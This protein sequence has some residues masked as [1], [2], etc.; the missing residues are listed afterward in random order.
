MVHFRKTYEKLGF[1]KRHEWLAKKKR[2]ISGI[3]GSGNQVQM[4][5]K[6]NPNIGGLDMIRL[7]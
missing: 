1:K 2:N 3:V 7:L 5:T 4:G 6:R